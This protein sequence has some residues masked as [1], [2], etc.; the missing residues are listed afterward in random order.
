MKKLFTAIAVIALVCNA[1]QAKTWRINNDPEAKADFLSIDAAMASLDVFDGDV[2]YLDPGCR[3]PSQTVSKK[4]TIIGTGYNLTESDEAM[5]AGITITTND[6]KLT[7]LNVSGRITWNRVYN[8]IT[9]ERCKV[10]G[11]YMSVL[12]YGVK[13]ISCYIKGDVQGGSN[14][15]N[16]PLVLRNSIV[17]GRIYAIG[18]GIISNNVVIYNGAV[19][20]FPVSSINN[21]TISNNII[22]NTTTQTATTDNVVYYY[23]NNTIA[24]VTIEDNNN[25]VNNVLSTDADHAWAN[26]PTNKFIGAKVEDVFV[27]E[28]NQEEM[29]RLKEGSEAIGYGTNGV[30]CGV[31]DGMYPYVVHGRPQFVPYIYEAQIPH[32]PSSDGKLNITLK[33][34]S[35]NE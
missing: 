33:I 23:R 17:L 3:L 30:D 4:V 31:F 1:A 13:I 18:N 35:Q 34:K 28:G 6:I 32:A 16:S 2:L 7:G 25:I 12:C 22:I 27:N 29:Y 11:I 21:S 20:A 19:S 15:A 14:N 8:N 9:I 24:N 5:V 26:C 10:Q